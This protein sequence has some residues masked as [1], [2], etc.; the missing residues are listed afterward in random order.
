MKGVLTREK[1]KAESIGLII[2]MIGE[3]P[4]KMNDNTYSD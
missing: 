3:N 2:S 1:Q 4:L